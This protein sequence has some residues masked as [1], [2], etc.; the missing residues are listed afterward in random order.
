MGDT[1]EAES[2]RMIHTALDAGINLVDTADV[3]S[4]GESELV[5][6]R[7]LKSQAAVAVNRLPRTIPLRWPV[8]LLFARRAAFRWAA[9]GRCPP[10]G[11]GCLPVSRGGAG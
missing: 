2:G 10:G 6:G 3:Y 5:V 11:V 4:S 9:P 8:D 1:D 7:A